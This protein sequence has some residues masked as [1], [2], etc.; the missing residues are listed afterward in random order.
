[1]RPIDDLTRKTMP[2]HSVISAFQH[3]QG[4]S[5]KNTAEKKRKKRR[6]AEVCTKRH[7]PENHKQCSR[8]RA[9]CAALLLFMYTKWG[10]REVKWNQKDLYCSEILSQLW[11]QPSVRAPAFRDLRDRTSYLALVHIHPQQPPRYDACDTCA[12]RNPN[13]PSRLAST[14]LEVWLERGILEISCR[15]YGYLMISFIFVSSGTMRED[16]HSNSPFSSCLIQG[17]YGYS[18]NQSRHYTR[19]S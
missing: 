10:R 2:I 14:E 6:N 8:W 19:V 18:S 13:I 15:A 4:W 5:K 16:K 7:R 17:N 1:M 12:G 3:S 9:N 11:L